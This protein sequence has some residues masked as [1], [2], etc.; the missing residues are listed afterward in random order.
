VTLIG[1]S[2][3]TLVVHSSLQVK[4]VRELVELAYIQQETALYARVIKDA[5]I[6][7]E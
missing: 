4:S 2:P 6:R 3:N 1:A 5:R 7:I